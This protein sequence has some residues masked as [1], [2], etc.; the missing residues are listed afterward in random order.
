MQMWEF[1]DSPISQEVVGVYVRSTS[2]CESVEN[3][4]IG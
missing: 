3:A 2:F 1:N 4:E